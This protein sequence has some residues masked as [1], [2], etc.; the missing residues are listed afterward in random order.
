MA[1]EFKRKRSVRKNFKKL[2]RNRVKRAL[3]SLQHS[4]R[5]DAVHE[6]R[7]SIKELRALLRLMRASLS[8]ADYERCAITLR[9]AAN[10]LGP[11]RDAHV[12]LQ[13]LGELRGHFEREVKPRSFHQLSSALSANCRQARAELDRRHGSHTVTRLLNQFARRLDSV[14]L[15]RSGWRAIAPGLKRTYKNGRDCFHSTREKA[16]PKQFHEWRKRVKDLYYQAGLLRP[17]WP[18]QLHAV[19]AELKQL[20]QYLGDDHDLFMLVESGA[21]SRRDEHARKDAETL[22]ALVDERQKRLRAQALAIGERFYAEKPSVF[23]KR[24]GQY[25]KR[26]RRGPRPLLHPA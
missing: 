9:E 20:G 25:W 22:Q 16:T 24:L 10:Q 6:V 12:K 11:A 13:A 3:K 21:A 4:E 18:E 1:F 26:W 17:I 19:C 14:S 5:L 2:G 7:K 23:C 8:S 15:K